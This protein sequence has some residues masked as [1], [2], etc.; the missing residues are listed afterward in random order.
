MVP[1]P[2]AAKAFPSGMYGAFVSM[3]IQSNTHYSWHLPLNSAPPSQCVIPM[4]RP[5]G[6][7]TSWTSAWSPSAVSCLVL[8]GTPHIMG[9]CSSMNTTALFNPLYDSAEC[10]PHTSASTRSLAVFACVDD[11]TRVTA[12]LL[13]FPA[14]HTCAA[15]GTC[16]PAAACSAC[17]FRWPILRC[18]MWASSLVR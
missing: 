2:R 7:A 3:M 6:P 17:G 11:Q 8:V 10:F 1:K 18:H 12:L 4:Q 9:E 13:M 15:F 5:A 14:Q 16:P